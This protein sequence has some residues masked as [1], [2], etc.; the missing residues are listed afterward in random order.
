MFKSIKSLRDWYL[1]HIK[2][3]NYKIGT[4]F[5][6]G[7]RVRFWA[8]HQLTIGNNFYIGRDSQ[9]ETDCV[10]GNDVLIG[11]KVGIVGRYDHNYQQIGVPIRKASQIRDNDYNWK[12]LDLITYI[13]ND[14]WIG[15][16]ATI[17]GGV[18][19]GDGAIVAAGAVVTKDLDEYSIYAGNPAKR[20]KD[21]F[22]S[23]DEREAH[24][25]QLLK[26]I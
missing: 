24:K 6:A 8:K 9:I 19:I 17:M 22:N 23:V 10:I 5:H 3:R 1:V 20:I 15:Y 25:A 12:G 11:N 14:V 7:A 26:S 4:G 13:G 18:K 16:G 2:W 21:R